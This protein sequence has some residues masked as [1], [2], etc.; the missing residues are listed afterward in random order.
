MHRRRSL[1]VVLGVGLAL[2]VP[3]A[4]AADDFS[5]AITLSQP[6]DGKAVSVGDIA[7]RGS[8]VVVGWEERPEGGTRRVFIRRSTNGG[9]SFSAR[10]RLDT[11][12]QRAIRVETCSGSAWATSELSEVT[13]EWIIAL[14]KRPMSGSQVE[15]SVLTTRG[16]ARD[17]D[18]AC[19]GPRLVVAWFQRSDD[20][21]RVR[22]H[23]RGVH[24]ETGGSSLPA[25]DAD[26]G[27]GD[28]VKGLAVAATSDRVYVAW[29]RGD[30]LRIRRYRIG[31]GAAHQLTYLDTTT[32]P[33]SNGSRPRIAANGTGAAITFER[34]TGV[35]ARVS[36]NRG[37]SWG[38]QRTLVT[39]TAETSHSPESIAMR[40]SRIIVAVSTA[41]VLFGRGTVYRSSNDGSTWSEVANARRNGGRMVAALARPGSADRIVQVFDRT[42]DESATPSVRFRRAI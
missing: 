42:F 1:L 23:A 41:T 4:A 29:F 9:A 3:S 11:R 31:T 27:R 26:L 16:V 40:G 36:T 8:N 18:I 5:G 34:G 24:D 30:D 35:R 28:R 19:G 2:S 22:L 15:Q 17:P 13:G 39:S 38:P 14:D 7:A 33:M 20:G 10:I 21:W 12:P 32:Y 25:F 37:A 6:T